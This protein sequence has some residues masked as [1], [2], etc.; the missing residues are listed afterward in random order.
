MK[1]LRVIDAS[2]IPSIASSNINAVV[3][4]IAEK[5]SDSILGLPALKKPNNYSAP[6]AE[7]IPTLEEA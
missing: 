6:D 4:M 5:L 3:M 2:I 7:P 1:G